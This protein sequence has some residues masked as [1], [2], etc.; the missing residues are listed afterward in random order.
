MG[1][2]QLNGAKLVNYKFSYL[3]T[4][5]KIG[6]DQLRDSCKLVL[7]IV[8]NIVPIRHSTMVSMEAPGLKSQQRRELLILN[9]KEL[10]FI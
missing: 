6:Y 3:Q 10:L 2:V 4:V 9:K 7:V 1:S 8:V 5:N